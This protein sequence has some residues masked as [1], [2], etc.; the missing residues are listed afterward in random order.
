MFLYFFMMAS[1]ASW[2][3][4]Q[5]EEINEDAQSMW[6]FYLMELTNR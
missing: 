2:V 3:T 4:L 1:L 5:G 6:N